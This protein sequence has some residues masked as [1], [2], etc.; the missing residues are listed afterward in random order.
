MKSKK[1]IS[2]LALATLGVS[3][4]TGP[5]FATTTYPSATEAESTVEAQIVIDEETD[6]TI[7]GINPEDPKPPVDPENLNPDRA[8]GLSIR[9]VS[10]LDF[11]K[12]TFSTEEQTLVA[13]KDYGLN[14]EDEK[15]FFENMVTVEDIRGTRDGWTLTVSQEGDFIEGAVMTLYPNIVADNLGVSVPGPVEINPEGT[16]FASA[17]NNESGMAGVIS[18]GMGEADLVIPASTGVDTYS[19][20]LKWE[21]VSGPNS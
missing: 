20:T 14:E 10:G 1:I 2:T 4:S 12:T 21:L 13:S 15:V 11:G 7:P 19:A 17:N 5:V 8:N 18:I 16:V 6:G 3:I 9:Y